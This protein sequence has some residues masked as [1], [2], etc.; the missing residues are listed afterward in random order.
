MGFNLDTQY[1]YTIPGGGRGE[2]GTFDIS[3]IG[4]AG[5]KTV[6]VPT[7]L[8]T[9]YQWSANP[10]VNSNDRTPWVKNVTTDGD[11]TN[12]AVTFTVETMR[13]DVSET[14]F[15]ELKGW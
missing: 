3:A 8:L 9:I 6:D 10:K 7:R 12:G 14:I 13:T 2:A 1:S 15:Y 4:V 11:I 5:V